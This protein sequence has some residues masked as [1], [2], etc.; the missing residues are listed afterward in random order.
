MRVQDTINALLLSVM[1]TNTVH[2]RMRKRERG[3]GKDRERG[4]GGGGKRRK[5]REDKRVKGSNE[6]MKGGPVFPQGRCAAGMGYFP[7]GTLWPCM[8]NARIC[9]RCCRCT[10]RR[11]LAAL[12]QQL[13]GPA[14]LCCLM[15]V[16]CS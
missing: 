3:K 2:M 7:R 1:F 13:Q 9:S 15:W 12:A 5:E 11:K 10:A 8:V 4:G 6:K 14:Y 16:K